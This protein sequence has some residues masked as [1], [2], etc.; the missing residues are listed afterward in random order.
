M[1]ISFPD[2][3]R[4]S[5]AEA[6]PF[7]TGAQAGQGLVQNAMMFP[8][9]LQAKILANKIAQVQ[10]QYAQ[11][12]TQATLLAKQ[13]SNQW[14][15]RLNESTINLQGATAG[16][17]KAEAE[18]INYLLKHQ[19]YMGSDEAKTIQ[20]L[21]DIG[22]IKPDELSGNARNTSANEGNYNVLSGQQTGGMTPIPSRAG[23]MTM[24][25]GITGQSSGGMSLIPPEAMANMLG[26]ESG[27]Q[28]PQQ[29]Q[30]GQQQPEKGSLAMNLLSGTNPTPFN[31]QN[32]LLNSILNRKYAD[33][34]YQNKMNAAF[35]WVH[36]T[37]E[38]KNYMVAQLAGAGIDPSDAINRLAHGASVPQILQDSGFDPNNPPDPDFLPTQ[39][40]IATLKSRQA[41]LA[42]SNVINKFVRE[43]LGPYSQT[44]NNI[45][46]VQLRDALTGMNKNRQIKF[47]A[48]RMLAPEAGF[49]RIKLA[50]GQAGETVLQDI[51]NRSM[52]NAKAYQSMVSPEIF[53][54]AQELADEKLRESFGRAE[55]VYSVAKKKQAAT[56]K[57]EI[58]D[59]KTI[60]GIKFKKQNGKWVYA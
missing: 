8:Q 34:A 23:G 52:M 1:A 28:Q 55:K 53:D 48:A 13:I 12:M 58:S 25:P 21:L 44:I 36:S 20:Y 46:P 51:M 31:T 6:N 56:E 29:G 4:I 26:G 40:N 45:S 43:G 15:P 2:F 35:N 9:D 22:A 42:E 10:A 14:Q 17:Q 50:Q 24:I 3:G 27:Q 38:Q 32:P 59:T 39:G 18:K 47:L 19:G 54:K 49:I 37:P 5:F 60:N 11:P 57:T 16:Q 7:L 41:A 30:T 33:S